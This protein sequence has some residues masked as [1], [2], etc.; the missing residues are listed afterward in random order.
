MAALVVAML[1][2]AVLFFAYALLARF[3]LHGQVTGESLGVSVAQASGSAPF[4]PPVCE[5]DSDAEWSC[6]VFQGSDSDDY[7]VRV[8]TGSSCWDGRLV[9]NSRSETGSPD[10]ISGCVFRW[11]WHLL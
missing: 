2:A 4:G 8:R 11:Q 5:R 1:A 10:R 7:R 9:R 6:S 3:V